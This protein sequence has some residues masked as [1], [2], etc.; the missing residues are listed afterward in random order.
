MKL[1]RS[2]SSSAAVQA[3]WVTGIPARRADLAGRPCWHAVLSNAACR[4]LET[5][6]VSAS[7]VPAAGVPNGT[8]SVAD[9]LV[10]R[11]ACG[12]LRVNAV[13]SR[14]LPHKHTPCTALTHAAQTT[15]NAQSACEHTKGGN[16]AN[17]VQLATVSFR[18]G[19]YFCSRRCHTRFVSPSRYV[20]MS[21]FVMQK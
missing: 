10:T 1:G 16:S 13:S 15:R 6:G 2:L 3:L 18:R 7:R 17:A 5:A 9:S 14:S 11:P 12:G 20:F 8:A 19:D 21:V 4:G